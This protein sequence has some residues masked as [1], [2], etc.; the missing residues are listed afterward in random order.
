M[1]FVIHANL[2]QEARWAG[3]KLPAHVRARVSAASA[4]LAALAPEGECEV[5]TL[6]PVL[7]ARMLAVPGWTPPVLRVGAPPEADLVWAIPAAKDVNDRGY[8]LALAHEL[9]CALPGARTIA[10]VDEL[11]DHLA[12]GGA[13]ASA[14]EAWVCKARWTSAG[15]DRCFGTG[16]ALAGDARDEVGRFL[17][18]HGQLVFEPWLDRIVDLAICGHVAGAVT[19]DAPHRLLS[20]PR[21]GFRGIELAAS[22]L[23][24]AEHDI[25]L[26]TAERVGHA[27]LAAGYTG[28]FGIDAFVYRDRGRRR[29]HPLCEVNA[30]TTFGHVARALGRRLGIAALGFGT[31]PP[32]ATVLVAP[33]IDDRSS[34]W[35]T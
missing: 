5:W 20:T 1:T 34:A 29:L 4:L 21:G 33:G 15:R 13:A 25:L 23:E 31:A 27:L 35:V 2:D 7:A 28:P 8:G 30:R 9:G 11:E 16:R 14:D 32:G 10:A 18:R 24:L 6:A 26:M 19:V 3:R 22:G 17:E 12:A